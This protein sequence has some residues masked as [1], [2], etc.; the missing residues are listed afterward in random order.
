MFESIDFVTFSWFGMVCAIISAKWAAEL[1]MSQLSQLC[2]AV[3]G[4][5]LPPVALLALYAR[6]VHDKHSHSLPGGQLV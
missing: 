2:W 4:F 5:V 1:G 3:L 6:L